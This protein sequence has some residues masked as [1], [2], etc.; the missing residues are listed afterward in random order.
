MAKYR[1]YS[2]YILNGYRPSNP[3]HSLAALP[4]E[5]SPYCSDDEDESYASR[6]YTKEIKQKVAYKMLGV[7]AAAIL[8]GFLVYA[9][10]C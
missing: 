1:L 4:T 9:Y 6:R 10:W 8:A 3:H 7:Y 2:G 5:Q